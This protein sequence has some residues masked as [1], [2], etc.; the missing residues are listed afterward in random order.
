[1]CGGAFLPC[2]FV[3]RV[4]LAVVLLAAVGISRADMLYVS[5]DNTGLVE[6]FDLATGSDLGVL[7]SAGLS[8]PY[9]LSIDR[10]GNLYVANRA[11]NT[12]EWFSPAGV[13]LGN[14]AS[15]GLDSPIG[16]AFDR[17]GN[18]YA[19]NSGNNTIQKFTPAGVGSVFAGVGL[20]LPTDL[21]FDRAGNLYAAQASTD[22]NGIT[23]ILRFTPEGVGSVFASIPPRPMPQVLTGLAFDLSGNL[24]AA[25]F[26]NDSVM[27]FTPEGVGSYFGTANTRPRGLAFDSA[28][29]LYATCSGAGFH[30]ILKFTPDGV[31]SI[32]ADTGPNT[33]GYLAILPEPSTAF[34]LVWPVL[35]VA[36]RGH[37]SSDLK[38]SRRRN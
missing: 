5:Y 30:S 8:G 36:I 22:A 20:N 15:T 3:A 37:F 33:P 13:D 16:L 11:N 28:G 32:F 25:S 26:M 4:T 12:I 2:R 6:K 21:A 34:L 19:A 18:L 23:T 29:N 38:S 1:M 14:F 24:F 9:G 7:A 35:L 27:K 31:G 17:A 10:A